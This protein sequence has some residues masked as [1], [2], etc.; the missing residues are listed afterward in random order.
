MKN[1]LIFASLTAI[2]ASQGIADLPT[3]SL[4]CLSTAISGLGCDLTDFA[5]SCQKAAELTPVV[6]PCVEAACADPAD[7]TKTLEVLAGICAEVGFPIEVPEPPVSSTI[8]LP[9][10]EPSATEP[11]PESTTEAPSA[12][13]SEAPT[14]NLPSATDEP[15]YS[16]ATDEPAYP[17]ATDEPSGY[18]GMSPPDTCEG[19]KV[20]KRPQLLPTQP[21][22]CP[23]CRPPT[24]MPFPFPPS[25]TQQGPLCR[26]PRLTLFQSRAPSPRTPLV[27]SHLFLCLM[28][29]VCLPTLLAAC[30]SSRVRLRLLRCL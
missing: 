7:E 14:E 20:N 17:T 19:Q 5:C 30:P 6:T 21:T 4:S 26:F 29:L 13:S 1:T 11:A 9:T 8:P 22:T 18:P 3:C 12:S 23:T 16:T 28:V 27:H 15:E 25:L 2:V 10:P 24:R